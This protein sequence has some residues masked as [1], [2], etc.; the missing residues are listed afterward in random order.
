MTRKLSSFLT[1]V[2][3]ALNIIFAV[4]AEVREFVK[5]SASALTF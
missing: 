4:F 3:E 5:F 2:L 1:R